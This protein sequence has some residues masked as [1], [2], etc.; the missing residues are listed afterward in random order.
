MCDS[1][2]LQQRQNNEQIMLDNFV[3]TF[4][5]ELFIEKLHVERAIHV[6]GIR[7]HAD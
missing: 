2:H 3:I 4:S 5:S 1:N 7:T 6:D